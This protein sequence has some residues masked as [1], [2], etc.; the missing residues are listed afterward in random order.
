MSIYEYI[1]A[2]MVDGVEVFNWVVI[3]NVN[4]HTNSDHAPAS[5]FHCATHRKIRA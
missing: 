5:L 3:G 4:P 2:E 1:C